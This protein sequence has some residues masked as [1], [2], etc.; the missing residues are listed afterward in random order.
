MT[1]RKAFTIFVFT[2]FVLLIGRNLTF[3]PKFTL[4]SNPKSETL[5]LKNQIKEL[6]A[7]EKGSY[8]VYFSEL[9]NEEMSFG[10]NEHEM[11][12]AASINKLPIVSVLYYL[13]GK[14]ELDLNERSTIQEDDIQDYG[15]GEI[16]YEKP[17]GVYSLKT[18]AKLSLQKSDNTA[19]H[20][21]VKKIGMEKIQKTIEALGLTQTDMTN[22]KTSLFD[23]YILFRKIY[24][25]EITSSSLTKELLGFLKDT[26][27]E[28][29]LPKLLPKNAIVYHKTGDSVGS[30]H[31][32]GI[33]KQD[34][35]AF[36]VGAMTADVGDQEEKTKNTI[37]KIAKIIFDFEVNRK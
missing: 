10:I 26:D 25:G 23:M 19:A 4:F 14:G 9:D 24:K 35:T 31:D 18:L 20:V 16:R 7:K 36:F 15:T 17:G 13:A 8:D 21:L 5:N 29:R 22:N 6:I 32:V 34:D 37:A 30:I 27:I 3:L 33:V 2:L 28:D 12:T 11:H 1:K